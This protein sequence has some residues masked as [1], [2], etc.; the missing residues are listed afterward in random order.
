MEH[1]LFPGSSRSPDLPPDLDWLNVPAP[2]SPDAL[3]GKVVIL[4]F[5]TFG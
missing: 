3:R 4:D 2:L 1:L 5:W